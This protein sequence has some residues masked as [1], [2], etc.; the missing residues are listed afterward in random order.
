MWKKH[1]KKKKVFDRVTFS[2]RIIFSARPCLLLTNSYELYKIKYT[3]AI[4]FHKL[5]ALA[6]VDL[7]LISRRR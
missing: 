3:K 4:L 1:I 7:L 2:I 5:L 6:R